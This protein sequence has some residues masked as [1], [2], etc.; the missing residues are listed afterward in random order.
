MYTWWIED[1]RQHLNDPAFDGPL[2]STVVEVSY[3]AGWAVTVIGVLLLIFARPRRQAAG[4]A[5]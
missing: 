1:Q 2:S 3:V 5:P 4:L